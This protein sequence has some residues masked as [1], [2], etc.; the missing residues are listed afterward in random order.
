M[1][2]STNNSG[3]I[4]ELAELAAYDIAGIYH[5]TASI[6]GEV[7]AQRYLAH[8]WETFAELAEKPTKGSGLKNWPG[9]RVYLA[10]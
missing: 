10:K 4:I 3:R 9:Y 6:W 2:K 7:Q 5:V 8:L 1:G